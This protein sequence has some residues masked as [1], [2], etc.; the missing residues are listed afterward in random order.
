MKKLIITLLFCLIPFTTF[1]I[2]DKEVI[3]MY[4]RIGQLEQRATKCEQRV[5]KLEE[6]QSLLEVNLNALDKAFKQ[7]SKNVVDMLGVV[8]S[9]L[10]FK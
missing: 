1:A 10:S 3:G 7:F 4:D 5:E 8:I 2:S 6:R 9:K